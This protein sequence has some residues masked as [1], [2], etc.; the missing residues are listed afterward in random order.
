MLKYQSFL[1]I[2]TG[3][4]S[5]EFGNSNVVVNWCIRKIKRISSNKKF[6]I[7]GNGM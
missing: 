7:S 6:C 1:R 4:H 5:A 3:F 2:W